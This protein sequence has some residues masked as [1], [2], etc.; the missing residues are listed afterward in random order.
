[1]GLTE[2]RHWGSPNAVPTMLMYMIW[3]LSHAPANRHEDEVRQDALA[4]LL[5]G[6]AVVEAFS[7]AYGHVVADEIGGAPGQALRKVVKRGGPTDPKI[8]AL[9]EHGFNQA[10]LNKT[11]P[12]WMEYVK[13]RK[14]RNHFVHFGTTHE[15]IDIPGVGTLRGMADLKELSQLTAQTPKWALITIRSLVEFVGE[16]RGMTKAQASALA[17]NYLGIPV[18]SV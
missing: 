7:N 15:S 14:L 16:G 10:A 13:L 12:R 4:S 5:L 18:P 3:R 9:F 1:M 8:E 17:H 2:G 6:M 11:D